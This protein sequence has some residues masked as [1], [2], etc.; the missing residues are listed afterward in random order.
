MP[1]DHSKLYLETK[2]SSSNGLDPKA[3]SKWISANQKI[4]LGSKPQVDGVTT[5]DQLS[6]LLREANDA[7]FGIVSKMVDG[8][9]VRDAT[10][11][12][13]LEDRIDHH[14]P[15]IEANN[16]LLRC[17]SRLSAIDYAIQQN[18][19][20]DNHKADWWG[21]ALYGKYQINDKWATSVRGE[22]FNDEDG[23]RVVAGTQAEYAEIT[24]TLEYK[25][26]ENTITRLE[27][28]SDHAD[29]DLFPANNQTNDNQSTISSEVMYIF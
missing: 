10:D 17:L 1:Q 29:K 2:F 22:V 21:Q 20:G 14:S 28:R 15:V 18:A 13:G 4:S 25:P 19:L 27:W 3:L 12:I 23:M 8:K 5:Y 16:T 6:D 9:W 7:Q 26:W 11:S 24:A